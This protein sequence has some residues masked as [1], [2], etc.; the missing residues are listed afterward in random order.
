MGYV[1]S[2]KVN[3]VQ[4]PIGSSLYGTCTT[5]ANAVEKIVEL[6][7]FDKMPTGITIHVKFMNSNTAED[8]VMN[9]N[10]L[11]AKPIYCYSGTAPGKT[12]ESSWQ[13]GSVLSFTY[14]GA[15]WI[16]NDYSQTEDV[17]KE[18]D[19]INSDIAAIS[20]DISTINGDISAINGDI[21]SI[22]QEF[23]YIETTLSKQEVVDYVFGD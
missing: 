9:V 7:D 16:M 5:A 8:P 23:E 10:E 6:N 22:Y 3:G 13:P 18:I 14:D 11:G 21:S 1:A 17:Q 4:F 12:A 20:G 15:A 2:A 19:S